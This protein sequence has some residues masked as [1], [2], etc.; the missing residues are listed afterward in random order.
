M[1]RSAVYKLIDGEREYQEAMGKKYGWGQG[2]G[3][4]NHS[5]AEFAWMIEE[6]SMRL[7]AEWHQPETDKAKDGSLAM[8][9]KIAG[10][11]VAC[12]E[13]HGAPEREPLV[14]S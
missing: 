13:A 9:R 5:I 3:A 2:Q 1:D 10:L 14:D 11:A 8:M 4:S 6:Y 12:M 7:R